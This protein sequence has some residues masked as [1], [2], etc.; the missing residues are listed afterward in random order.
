MLV[1]AEIVQ[2]VTD[3]AALRGL[4]ALHLDLSEVTFIDSSGLR[5]LLLSRHAVLDRGL[6]F[7]LSMTEGGPVH[8]LLVLAGVQEE[9]AAELVCD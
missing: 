4:T 6:K 8:R 7:S 2:T 5:S 1:E 9:L 3:T